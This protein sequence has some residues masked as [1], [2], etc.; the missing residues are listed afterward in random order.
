MIQTRCAAILFDLDGVLVDS[1]ACVERHWKRW[2]QQHNLELAEILRQAHGQRTVETIAA[3]APTLDAV[4]E[5]EAIERAE[6]ADSEGI[7][8]L[9]GAEAL[10]DGLPEAAWAVVTSGTRRLALARLGYAGLPG[11]RY[12]ITAED[13][14]NGK[15]DPECYVRAA[16]LLGREASD[17]VAVED[18]PAG[19]AAAQAAGVRVVAL[20]TT[21]PPDALANA[22]FFVSSLAATRARVVATADNQSAWNSISGAAERRLGSPA[23]AFQRACE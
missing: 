5:A 15:P 16:T 18:A 6:A 11:P 14:E 4:Q 17:C 23:P 20:G 12:L 13:V 10:L 2:A 9:P 21:H 19:I 8:A 7:V 22:D 3:V 1:R